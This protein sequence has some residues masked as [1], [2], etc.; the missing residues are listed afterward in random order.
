MTELLDNGMEQKGIR[1]MVVTMDK[2]GAV[3]I[4]KGK[5]KGMCPAI[6]TE[7]IDS[8]G[9]G[10]SFFAGAAAA[11]VN[12]YTLADACRIGS[13]MA[14]EVIKTTENVYRK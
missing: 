6:P 10:D 4:D 11:M 14:S 12:G 3:Y 2:D 7:I 8:T 5:E 1:C 9:A 13:C